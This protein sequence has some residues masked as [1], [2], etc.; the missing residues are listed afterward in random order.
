LNDH[1]HDAAN[2]GWLFVDGSAPADL[3]LTSKGQILVPDGGN[4]RLRLVI[5]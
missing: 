4:F 2:P 3:F 5:P 1:S